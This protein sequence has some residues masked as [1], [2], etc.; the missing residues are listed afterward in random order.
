MR[1]SAMLSV[2]FAGALFFQCYA[3]AAAAIPRSKSGAAGISSM[4]RDA[5]SSLLAEDPAAVEPSMGVAGDDDPSATAAITVGRGSGGGPRVIVM[6]ADAAMLRSLREL[7]RGLSLYKQHQQRAGG[8]WGSL[9]TLD[10]GA[11]QQQQQQGPGLGLGLLKRD[12]MR[13][14]VGRVYRPCW[15]A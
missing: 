15:E 1:Q 13:C 14:M 10:R 6:L 2:L 11:E 7:D 9:P 3:S 5:L 8:E 12:T 4:E